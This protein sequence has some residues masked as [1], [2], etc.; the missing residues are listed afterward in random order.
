MNSLFCRDAQTIKLGGMKRLL[1]LIAL[2]LFA[3][4]TVYVQADSPLPFCPIIC[5]NGGA[6]GN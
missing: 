3:T 1:L 6:N 5:D 2:T 4:S